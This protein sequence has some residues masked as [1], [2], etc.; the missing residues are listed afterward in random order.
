MKSIITVSNPSLS[1]AFLLAAI[2]LVIGTTRAATITVTNTEDDGIGSLRDAVA[3]AA[4]GDTIDF[5]LSGCP[6]TITLTSGEIFI[7]K[8]LTI[9][10]LGADVLAVSGNNTSRIFNISDFVF[11]YISGLTL[12]NGNAG[13][14]GNA[15][16]AIFNDGMLVVNDSN[17]SGNTA[18][19]NPLSR[20]GGIYNDLNSIISRLYITNSTISG[21]T[22]ASGG[23]I[24]NDGLMYATNST[25]SNNTASDGDG[26]GIYLSNFTWV[27]SF[28]NCTISGNTGLNYG[29][30]IYR[31]DNPI[32]TGPLNF[33]YVSNTIIA[34]NI[35]S[36]NNSDVYGDFYSAG[37]NLIGIADG[38]TGFIQGTDQKGTGSSPLDPLLG[39]LQNNGGTT[40][41][42][43]L[44]TGSP[45]IDK[46]G[47]AWDPI[48][49]NPL[50]QDQRG[51]RR[52]ADHPSIPNAMTGSDIGAFELEYDSGD[53]SPPV[54]TPTVSGTLGNNGWYTS[55]VQISWSVV[56]NESA[57]TIFFG[58]ETQTFSYDIGFYIFPC[59]A[60]SAGG[61]SILNVSIKRDATAPTIN[62]VSRTPAVNANGWD[63]TDV[64]V[65]WNCSDALSGSVSPGDSQTISAEGVNLSAAGTCADNAGN[66]ASDTQMG[67]NIDKTAPVL[68][69]TV[70]PNPVPL[71]GTATASPNATDALSGIASQSCGAVD[72]STAGS[73]SV[74][75]TATDNAGN[76]A[77]ASASYQVA[78]GFNF[79]GFFQPVDNLPTV[80][81]VNAGQSIPIKFSLG[82]N[83]GLNIFAAG[84]PVS[85]QIGCASGAPT[86]N[87][88]ET[89]TAG[90]SSLTYDAAT[91]RYSYVWRTDRAWRG[92]CR[93]LQVR[94]TDGSTYVAN[95]QFR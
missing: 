29:S 15:G 59:T 77:N 62:F 45:A 66:T 25:I 20:G 34:G 64:S 92:T 26:G 17:I 52:Y 74:A 2:F 83:F 22:A 16:G 56:D 85:V 81:V 49:T 36:S 27:A 48:T 3:H 19:S 71:N 88:E 41:T 84:S 35:G 12:K 33:I 54:I 94:L 69:P 82:G 53:A 18:G 50:T 44:L 72:T 79:V 95:F 63:N 10:G 68:N 9:N 89:V 46:G 91:D 65:N 8:W 76:T 43:A 30:G 7:N 47:L 55:D 32:N 6:C 28:S 23:G 58:C 78:G 13:D 1:L 42:Q 57:V 86:N 14:A 37:G 73:H 51:M 5:N 87:I 24:Y 61:T 38:S 93:Q 60:F 40:P 75:C 70:S 4:S 21:N 39:P 67:I 11:V 80:N 31:E 90:G